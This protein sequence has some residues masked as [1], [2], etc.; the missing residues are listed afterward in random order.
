MSLI[1]EINRTNTSKEKAK[2]VAVKIDNKLVELGGEQAINLADVPN[3]MQKMVVNNY[4]KV[5]KFPNGDSKEYEAVF[6][7]AVNFSLTCEYSIDFMPEIVIFDFHFYG[8]RIYQTY[9]GTHAFIN[10]GGNHPN[11]DVST[12]SPHP[13]SLRIWCKIKNITITNN[14]ITF[15]GVCRYQ[16]TTGSSHSYINVAVSNLIL[17]DTPK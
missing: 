3:K 2:T 6:D 17:M 7:N 9:H 15:E 12:E 5:A 8:G 10:I 1:T 14:K 16:N 11:I 4:A 13:S